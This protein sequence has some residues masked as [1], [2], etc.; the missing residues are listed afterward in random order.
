MQALLQFYRRVIPKQKQRIYILPTRYGVM[1]GFFL[2]VMFLGAINYSNSMGHLLVFLLASLGH[3]TMLHTHR[4][5]AKIELKYA[6]SEPVY[7]GQLASFNIVLSNHNDRDLHQFK[8]ATRTENIKSW[9]ALQKVMKGFTYRNVLAHIN[10]NQTVSTIVDIST[11]KRGYQALGTVQLSSQFPLGLFNCW[12]NYKTDTNVLVYPK[13]EGKLPLPNALGSGDMFKQ[14]KEKGLDDFAGFNTYR[15]GDPVHTIAWK[16]VARDGVLRTKQFSGA[17]S[18]RRV[19]TWNDTAGIGDTEKR[20]S[21]LCRWL[22]ETEN[23]STMSRL[24]L[25]TKVIDFAVGEKHL[26]ECLTA[27]ALYHDA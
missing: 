14:S 20:L 8:F 4:N 10:A 27:L 12:T 23:A 6:H 9:N 17:Q 15:A 1:F 25:P 19:L 21:Q 2:F 11:E 26:H 7:C 24:E 5:I 13:P 16:A 3:T 18:G 22:I